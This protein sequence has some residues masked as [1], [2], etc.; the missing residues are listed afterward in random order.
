MVHPWWDGDRQTDKQTDKQTD[1]A[2]AQRPRFT[3]GGII[4]IRGRR[5]RDGVRIVCMEVITY[6]GSNRNM[7]KDGSSM[8]FNQ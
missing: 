6:P 7:Q 4:D 2:V 8:E 3:G 5:Y 1:I